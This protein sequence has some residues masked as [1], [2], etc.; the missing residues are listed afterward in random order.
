ME[1]RTFG[2]LRLDDGV[3]LRYGWWPCREGMHCGTVVILSGRTEFMEKYLDTIG[4][5]NGRGFDVF[6]LDWRGQGLSDRLLPDPTKGYIDSYDQYVTDLEFFFEKIVQPKR[7]SPTILMAHSMG[8][9]ILLQF[10]KKR[11]GVIDKGV[12]ISPMIDIRTDPL[13]D[14]VARLACRLMVRL[15]KGAKS[16]PSLKRNDSFRRSFA[17]N[18]L[19]HDKQR[20]ERVQQLIVNDPRLGVIGVTYSWLNASFEAID[21]LQQPGFAKQISIPMLVVAAGGDRIVSNRAVLKFAAQLPKHQLLWIA[22][23]HHELL[24]ELDTFQDRFWCAF[25]RFVQN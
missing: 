18:R 19:T 2:F 3:R 10:L 7:T 1:D 23:A 16:V 9:N 12:I 4:R 11:I 22:G 20:F 25:D 17:G 5:M 24:Q 14:A 6:S 8:A 15:G 13:P 21:R